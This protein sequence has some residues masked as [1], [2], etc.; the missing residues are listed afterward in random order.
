MW[1]V[2]KVDNLDSSLQVQDNIVKVW[3]CLL[4]NSQA[5]LIDKMRSP[6]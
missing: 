2:I 5:Y 1:D 6:T 3:L 4:V